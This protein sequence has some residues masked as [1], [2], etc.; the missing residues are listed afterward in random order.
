MRDDGA[1]FDTAR[2]KAA[3]L[4]RANGLCEQPKAGSPFWENGLCGQPKAAG[5]LRGER[6]V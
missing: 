4:L 2:P 3:G 1:P 5:L 6:V